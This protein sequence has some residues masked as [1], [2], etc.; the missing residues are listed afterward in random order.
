MCRTNSYIY[1][2]RH[3]SFIPPTSKLLAINKKFLMENT[4]RKCGN[5]SSSILA[6]FTRYILTNRVY[7]SIANSSS[8]IDILNCNRWLKLETLWYLKT[9][10]FITGCT[11]V[12]TKSSHLKA[13][14]RIH[15]GINYTFIYLSHCEI[16]VHSHVA[17]RIST[18]CTKYINLHVFK[19]VMHFNLTRQSPLY[20]R[21]LLNGLAKVTDTYT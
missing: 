17:L 12:Y 21:G 15:T 18:V 20:V 7:S 14:Q 13:H 8:T 10:L 5:L 19:E 4:I 11:K 6:V 16:T 1:F 2:S 9:K 3:E